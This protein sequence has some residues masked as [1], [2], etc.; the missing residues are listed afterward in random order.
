[1]RSTSGHTS[2]RPGNPSALKHGARRCVET[3]LPGVANVGT[4]LPAASL[5]RCPGRLRTAQT[6]RE[7]ASGTLILPKRMTSHFGQ[8][9]P[10]GPAQESM[11]RSAVSSKG[12]LIK[13]EELDLRS[14][15]PG[16]CIRSGTK[17]RAPEASITLLG[18]PDHLGPGRPG[19]SLE[20]LGLDRVRG[21][22]ETPFHTRRYLGAAPSAPALRNSPQLLCLWTPSCQMHKRTLDEVEGGR[23]CE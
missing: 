18:S 17:W 23:S 2:T 19:A 4:R 21:H 14:N 5:G 8:K 13:D 12:V 10:A 3:S 9:R 22:Q 1:M 11:L 15:L 6:R 7:R 20:I 16:H